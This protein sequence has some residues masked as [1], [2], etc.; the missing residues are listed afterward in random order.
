MTKPLIFLGGLC[1]LLLVGFTYVSARL[2]DRA[3]ISRAQEQLL[4]LTQQRDSITA[5]VRGRDSMQ[6]RLQ[7]SVTSLTSLTGA[8]RDSVRSLETE[9][10]AAVL[11][12]R[13]LQQT[14]AL[15]ARV[16]EVFPEVA[17]SSHWGIVEMY[18]EKEKVSLEYIVFPAWFSETFLIDHE[19]A[20]NYRAQR[21]KLATLD[22]LNL[23]VFRLKDS[24][25][26]LEQQKSAAFH[27]GYDSAY[28]KYDRLNAE[29]IATLKNPR[30]KL[31]FPSWAALIGSAAVGVAI[32]AAIK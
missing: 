30:I 10:R 19:N 13:R 3:A 5:F 20:E 21:D 2:A 8:L 7:D 1:I 11:S 12:I 17:H 4:V 25:L 31:G 9:R 18:D 29:Y 26:V 16:A 28:A 14:P 24:V 23:Q 32:G 27:V 15:Q 6:S 22:T